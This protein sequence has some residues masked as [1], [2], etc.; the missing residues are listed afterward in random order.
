VRFTTMVALGS[1]AVHALGLKHVDDGAWADVIDR[2]LAAARPAADPTTDDP[3]TG[4][5]TDPAITRPQ[6]DHR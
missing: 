2:M 4:D 6:G 1:I 3:A 5:S